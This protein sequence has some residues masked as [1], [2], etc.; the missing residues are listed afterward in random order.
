MNN[1]KLIMENMLSEETPRDTLPILR[2][3]AE[4]LSETIEALNHI[5]ESSYWKVLQ[6]NVFDVDLARAKRRLVLEKD[7]TEIFRLQGEIRWGEKFSLE[8]LIQKYRDEL[9]GIKQKINE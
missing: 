1:A 4:D 8:A 7:T 6:K 3:R 9:Q 5:A 2:E